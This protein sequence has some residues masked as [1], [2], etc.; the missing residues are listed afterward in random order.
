[1]S[2]IN[3]EEVLPKELIDMIQEY[4]DGQGI[5]IPAKEKKEWGSQTET[6]KYYKTRNDEICEK[7]KNGIPVS[8]LA[9]SYALSEKSIQ[10]I[11]RTTILLDKETQINLVS[12]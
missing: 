6:K 5:Y 11:L 12:E 9:T 10:R 1:M 7:Y 2:Y 8:M 4:V 3:A